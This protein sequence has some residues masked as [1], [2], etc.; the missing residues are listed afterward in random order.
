MPDDVLASFSARHPTD[1]DYP[2]VCQAL[3]DWW[4]L[5]GTACVHFI[6]VGPRWR[7]QGLGRALYER[8]FDL[9]KKHGRSEVHCIT[10]PPNLRSVEFHRQMGFDVKGP[11]ADYDGPGIDRYVFVRYL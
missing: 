10:S 3:G 7:K 8:F 4:D 6:G 1:A 5:A 9:C 2:R 11:V